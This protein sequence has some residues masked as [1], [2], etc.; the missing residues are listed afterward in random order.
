MQRTSRHYAFAVNLITIIFCFGDI[1]SDVIY[2]ICLQWSA[3]VGWEAERA[4]GCKKSICFK[5][6][7][8]AVS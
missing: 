6:V 5:T 7:V 2:I 3:A 1:L 8:M 4:S